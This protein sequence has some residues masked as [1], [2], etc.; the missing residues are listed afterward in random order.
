MHLHAAV[1]ALFLALV[2]TAGAAR[3]D[4][5]FGWVDDE[6]DLPVPDAIVT[7]FAGTT[8]V[9][10]TIALTDGYYELSLPAGTYLVRVEPP[11]TGGYLVAEIPNVSVSGAT[12]RD[13]LM[14][15]LRFVLTWSLL[16]SNGDGMPQARVWIQGPG[17]PRTWFDPDP[18]TGALQ[19][20]TVRAGSHQLGIE[21]DQ[22]RSHDDDAAPATPAES[23][24]T[25]LTI[26]GA[27]LDIDEDTQLDLRVPL[28]DLTLVVRD[29]RGVD[30]PGSLVALATN[31]SQLLEWDAPTP[32]LIG[33][34]SFTQFRGGL[35][36]ANTGADGRAQLVVP[37]SRATASFALKGVPP[38]ADKL[39]PTIAAGLAWTTDT[40]HVIT[41][42]D[43][44]RLSGRIQ[45]DLGG[46]ITPVGLNG[47]VNVTGVDAHGNSNSRSL[48]CDAAG[49]FGGDFFP[50]P[51]ANISVA[52]VNHIQTRDDDADPATPLEEVRTGFSLS[53]GT[54]ALE[55]STD[56]TFT[57][58]LVTLTLR[59]TDPGGAD[60]AR[61]SVG[62][63][64]YAA[65]SPHSAGGVT[66]STFSGSLNVTNTGAD[67]LVALDLPATAPT[68]AVSLTA[69]P[70]FGSELF[71][72]TH[73]GLTWPADTTH[74][75]PLGGRV[76]FAG[77]I[78]RTDGTPIFGSRIRIV[79]PTNLGLQTPAADGSFSYLLEPGSYTITLENSVATQSY[80]EDTDP[81][82]VPDAERRLDYLAT[83]EGVTIDADT[84]AH[85]RLPLADVCFR[86]EDSAAAPLAN[87]AI[88]QPRYTSDTPL[89]TGGLTFT[90]FKG[91]FAG[92]TGKSGGVCFSAPATQNTAAAD[93]TLTLSRGGYL[94]RAITD[95]VF[96]GDGD[97]FVYTLERLPELRGTV[98][99]PTGAVP[100]TGLR[101]EIDGQSRVANV[102][103][104]GSFIV[105]SIP[106]GT[107]RVRINNLS[108]IVQ[109]G[110][111]N[112]QASTNF[113][114]VS[115]ESLDFQPDDVLVRDF[116]VPLVPHTVTFLDGSGAPLSGINHRMA[117]SQYAVPAFTTGGLT[118]SGTANHH[119]V[120]T[121]PGHSMSWLAPLA[122]AG[123]SVTL[124]ATPTGF[125]FRSSAVTY[126]P[127][128]DFVI[129]IT[130]PVI[131]AV[132][133]EHSGAPLGLV[134]T[135]DLRV[136]WALSDEGGVTSA[137]MWSTYV[138]A[139]GLT[140][141]RMPAGTL[142]ATVDAQAHY[143][144]GEGGAAQ[145]ARSRFEV[146]ALSHHLVASADVSTTLRLNTRR[147][148]V[149]VQDR[150]G[151]PIQGVSLNTNLY[152][153]ESATLDGVA[154]GDLRGSA[155]AALGPTGAIELV[156]PRTK[157]S[158]VLGITLT[159]PQ[160]TGFAALFLQTELREDAGITVVLNERVGPDDPDVDG[161][162]TP[163]D[164]CP[165]VYNPHQTDS[166]GDG[167]GDACECLEVDCD[168]GDPCTA[169][170]CRETDGTCRHDALPPPC[171]ACVGAPEICDGEDND[172]DGVVDNHFDVLCDPGPVFY[173]LVE[174][175]EG[176]TVGTIRCF[177]DGA[178]LACDTRADAPDELVVYPA[179]LCP[180]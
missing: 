15:S 43:M 110:P 105:G 6:D 79:G 121:G 9:A 179:L 165:T 131:D 81:G 117:T 164:N 39:V 141:A 70:P 30:R 152:S 61:A 102:T 66:F 163:T 136:Q 25:T 99:L 50:T 142:Q 155:Q 28:V 20:I 146:S 45:R 172:C 89:V 94:N 128:G 109:P 26:T 35:R 31:T 127:S 120:R 33:G 171:G 88:T 92:T 76:T 143:T 12:R 113:S 173:A 103:A 145:Y 5:L 151:T 135:S 175:D 154:W 83:A 42:A 38:T 108:L 85:F 49:E 139:A 104:N 67:G 47:R 95:Q 2:V 153:G 59:V 73:A 160:G 36:V 144:T 122:A 4:T 55:T 118:F 64:S 52:L 27:T 16:R 97:L 44:V 112:A 24:R 162:P 51:S 149:T 98:L 46:V 77:S 178:S 124:T 111:G 116:V 11:I 158:Q 41:C 168:D 87:V 75:L 174:D 68:T 156:L 101:V 140:S 72:R 13:V 17:M 40:T 34:L 10:S 96:D 150:F 1:G 84:S 126:P 148:L 90:T 71:A 170:G 80:D 56:R 60:V 129:A 107:H 82:T 177:A 3:A 93:R 58:P 130:D 100:P 115:S 23:T 14:T 29:T 137:P 54:I 159:P 147:L 57:V 125:A 91:G 133:A 167:V 138:D 8:P 37:S 166:D 21:R 132:L 161:L 134:S 63:T 106:V 22:S 18:A 62:G 114:V 169:D 53:G 7:A 74:V 180:E 48:D 69:S 19:T 119:E 157:P 86:I 78:L 123:A 65:T 176:F 32:V